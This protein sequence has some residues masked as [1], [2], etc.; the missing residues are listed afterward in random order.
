MNS[1]MIKESMFLFLQ[2][3]LQGNASGAKVTSTQL[4]DATSL[5]DGFKT[6]KKPGI[7]ILQN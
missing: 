2:D 6:Q 7:H 5:L 1:S 4:W 3:K